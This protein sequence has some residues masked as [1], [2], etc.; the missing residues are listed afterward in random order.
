MGSFRRRGL[1]S[2]LDGGPS[3]RGRGL[4]RRF[5]GRRGVGFCGGRMGHDGASRVHASRPSRAAATIVR[6]HRGLAAGHPGHLPR[7]PIRVTVR[8]CDWYSLGLLLG[9]AIGA[10]TA[11]VARAHRRALPLLPRSPKASR[12]EKPLSRGNTC[13]CRAVRSEV[14]TN[15]RESF[16]GH[17]ERSEEIDPSN[18]VTDG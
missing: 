8:R 6:A 14:V 2:G 12:C 3:L 13:L 9:P 15:W 4:G 7:A 10:H 1:S 16:R 17:S 11:S 18:E 5:L